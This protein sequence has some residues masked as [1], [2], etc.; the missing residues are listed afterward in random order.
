MVVV[1]PRINFSFDFKQA[2]CT[3]TEE[4]AKLF[5]PKC[6]RKD[7][8]KYT[9]TVSNAYGTETADIPVVVLGKIV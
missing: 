8:G 6:E 9:I 2:Q 1:Q 7:T 4:D 3:S 5:I